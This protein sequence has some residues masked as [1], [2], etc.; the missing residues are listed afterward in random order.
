[1]TAA[2]AG[3]RQRLVPDG[4]GDGEVA[5]VGVEDARSPS[6]AW[7]GPRDLVRL[8][9]ALLVRGIRCRRAVSTLNV[10]DTADTVRLRAQRCLGILENPR[11]EWF[12]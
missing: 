5:A 7:L 6:D 2:A 4:V 3:R 9:W 1:M 8:S 12:T 10:S 11:T